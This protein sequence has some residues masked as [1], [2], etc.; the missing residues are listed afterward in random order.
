MPENNLL[1]VVN[2][3]Y[4]FTRTGSSLFCPR[5]EL[6]LERV[7]KISG[8]FA[9][10][11]IVNDKHSED[12]IEF[13]FL[14]EH[15]VVGTIDEQPCDLFINSLKKKPMVFHKYMP[16]A[17]S[18]MNVRGIVRNL[19]P[20]NIYLTGFMTSIDI[21]FTAYS[22]LE[23]GKNVY[24]IHGCCADLNDSLH[25]MGIEH[26]SVINCGITEYERFIDV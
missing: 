9:N 14:P 6:C 17:M 7:A 15:C 12:D 16:S 18:N 5:S 10:T 13:S 11:M 1:L 4:G 19:A 24:I 8:A 2:A 20:K 21:F 25:K 26:A 3:N 23:L 22:I